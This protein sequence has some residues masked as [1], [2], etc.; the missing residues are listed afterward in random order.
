MII[1]MDKREETNSN[2]IIG[3]LKLVL[4]FIIGVN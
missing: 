3:R 1:G 4:N 2:F